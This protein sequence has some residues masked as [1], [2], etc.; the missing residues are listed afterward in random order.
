MKLKTRIIF[1]NLT[2]LRAVPI[3]A[4]DL[5]YTHHRII[6][7]PK[8]SLCHVHYDHIFRRKKKMVIRRKDGG[9]LQ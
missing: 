4:Y 9:T 1:V 2:A 6:Q 5:D 7:E 8:L 3:S